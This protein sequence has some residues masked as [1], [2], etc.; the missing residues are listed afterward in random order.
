MA[1]TKVKYPGLIDFDIHN[2]N[3][4]RLTKYLEGSSENGNAQTDKDG[5]A[6][7]NVV[8][9]E[10]GEKMLKSMKR[11]KEKIAD[12]KASMSNLRGYTPDVQKVKQVK[13]G[14]NKD[15]DTMKN[16]GLTTKKHNNTISSNNLSTYL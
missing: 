5:E 1:Q 7:G 2:V 6:L 16:C 8:P 4:D 10:L 11:R 15:M 12:Q 13:E 14:V 3:M 9:S